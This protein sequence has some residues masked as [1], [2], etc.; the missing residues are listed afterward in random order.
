MDKI[1]ILNKQGMLSDEDR[2]A[3]LERGL[4]YFTFKTCLD[5]SSGIDVFPYGNSKQVSIDH[6][7]QDVASFIAF[8]NQFVAKDLNGFP[9]FANVK[10][11]L[12]G[13]ELVDTNK[14]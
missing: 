13:V 14:Q 6:Y 7:S 11:R 3:P 5:L 12:H 9:G 4:N 8:W 2:K 1:N 10:F